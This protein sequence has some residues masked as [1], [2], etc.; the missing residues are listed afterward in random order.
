MLSIDV[1]YVATFN[2]NA[3]ASLRIDTGLMPGPFIGNP[4]APV[5]VLALNPGWSPQDRA[6]N[7]NKVFRMHVR[8]ML[9]HR[10]LGRP[11]YALDGDPQR[12]GAKWWRRNLKQVLSA[13][14]EE[15]VAK[16]LCCL[17]YFPYHSKSF[18]H[19]AVRLPSQEYTFALLRNAIKRD[20]VVVMTRG[21][22]LWYGAVPELAGYRHLVRTVNARSASLSP[23]NCGPAF[24]TVVRR[25]QQTAI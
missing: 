4:K 12:P 7:R 5:I 11:F 2:K 25:L 18:G 17:E 6:A 24:G 13:V 8:A 20:A 14:S 3:P 23:R 15:H 10:F 1:P 22:R 16:N 9:V 21:A 19:A